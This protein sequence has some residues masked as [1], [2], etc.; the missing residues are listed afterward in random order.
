MGESERYISKRPRGITLGDDN[1]ALIALVG[2][3]ALMFICFGIIKGIYLLTGSNEMVFQYEILRWAILPAKLDYLSV[4][5]WTVVSYMFIHTGLITALV[6]LLWL[7]AFGRILQLMAG[8]K[9]IIPLYLYGGLAGAIF[10]VGASYLFPVLRNQIEYATLMGANAAIIAIA[11]A[12]TFIVPKFKLFPM[13]NGG[14]PL[15]VLTAIFLV[16]TF[17]SS[18]SNLANV[19]AYTGGA[20]IGYIFMYFYQ[21]GRNMG[22]WMIE[23]YEWFTQLFEPGKKKNKEAARKAVF[24]KTGGRKP[25]VKQPVVTQEKIDGILDKINQLGYHNLTEEE[26]SILRKASEEE[27]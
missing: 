16:I 21:R 19:F 17:V 3:N 4:K 12:V 10:F 13:I 18:S 20:L 22:L 11:I 9:I 27:F 15:W 8:N 23:L 24:Y 1:N 7:W 25:Y 14:I 26:K 5:P 6:N 2:I